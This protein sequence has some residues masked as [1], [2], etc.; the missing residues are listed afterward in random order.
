MVFLIY[1]NNRRK[2]RGKAWVEWREYPPQCIIVNIDYLDFFYFAKVNFSKSMGEILLACKVGRSWVKFVQLKEDLFR[3]LPV[4]S[5]GIVDWHWLGIKDISGI[6]SDQ[7]S[8]TN[9]CKMSKS[10]L[11]WTRLYASDYKGR[12][13]AIIKTF[14]TCRVSKLFGQR[15]FCLVLISDFSRTPLWVPLFPTP[16]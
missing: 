2:L 16:F 3:R 5:V 7:L 13:S 15:Q 14:W 6:P 10:L 8:A 9:Q 11:V 1:C 12:R 4:I